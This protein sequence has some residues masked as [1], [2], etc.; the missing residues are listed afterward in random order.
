MK[1]LIIVYRF[2]GLLL[3]LIL[4]SST[5]MSQTDD[6]FNLEDHKWQHRVLLMFSPNSS[7][8]KY[9]M[10]M[11]RLDSQEAKKGMNERDLKLFRVIENKG[12]SLRDLVIPEDQYESL[13]NRFNVSSNAYAL[14]LIGKDGSEKE[15]YT[16]AVKASE[17]FE[18]IDE[19]PMRKLE[20][21]DD[22]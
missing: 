3:T 14:I 1:A 22:G 12:I 7:D 9:R 2:T 19:M 5:A 20:M 8:S 4:V 11:K 15:R 13:R 17:I 6:Y 18:R 10:Q 21:K 16:S